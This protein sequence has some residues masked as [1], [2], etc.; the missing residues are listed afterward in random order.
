MAHEHPTAERIREAISYDP[1]AGILRWTE[2]VWY[3]RRAGQIAGWKNNHGYR[4]IKLDGKTLQGHR[5]AWLLTHGSWPTHQIDHI[6]GDR[7]D[8]RLENLREVPGAIN[9]QNRRMPQRNNALGAMG[10]RFVAA[11]RKFH[12]RITVN[13]RTTSLGYFDTVDA[14]SAAYVAAK[15]QRHE[16]C[17]L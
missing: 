8:N 3:G 17:T 6:N 11:R 9:S 12:A 14:A 13:G 10:V 7:A 1:A 5:V 15:R 2:F 16:G 4:V